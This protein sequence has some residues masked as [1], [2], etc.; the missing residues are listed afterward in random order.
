MEIIQEFLQTGM[1]NFETNLLKS[2]LIQIWK[3]FSIYSNSYEHD[4]LK[5]LH[6]LSQDFLSCLPVKFVYF[7]KSRLSLT[8]REFLRF[9]TK[10]KDSNIC[11]ILSKACESKFWVTL[12]DNFWGKKYFNGNIMTVGLYLVEVFYFS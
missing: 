12:V 7:V 4:A 6:F 10:K 5:I 3:S 1:Q 9:K 2:I 11:L 8:F